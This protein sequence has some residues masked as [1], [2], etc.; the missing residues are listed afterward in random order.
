MIWTQKD[1]ITLKDVSIAYR[2]AKADLFYER[3]HPNAIALCKYEENLE[4]NLISL[5]RKLS[6]NNFLWMTDSDF[7]GN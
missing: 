7:V 4:E 1:F 3:S 5:Y 6:S 2:K